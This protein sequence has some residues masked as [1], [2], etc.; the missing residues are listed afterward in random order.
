MGFMIA[1]T[2]AMKETKC[3]GE[4]AMAGFSVLL[5]ED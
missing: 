4:N 2:G 5:S 1:A 3:A